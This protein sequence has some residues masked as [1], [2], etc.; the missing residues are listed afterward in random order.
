MATS[1]RVFNNDDW[2]QIISNINSLVAQCPDIEPLEPVDECHK[3]SKEDIMGAQGKLLEGCPSNSFSPIPDLWKVA[4]IQELEDAIEAGP[5]CAEDCPLCDFELD[6]S[7]D[8]PQGTG[9]F[10]DGWADIFDHQV[11][12]N[13]LVGEFDDL[14]LEANDIVQEINDLKE[15]LATAAT[16]EAAAAIQDMID[17]KKEELDDKIDEAETK[18]DEIDTLVDQGWDTIYTL[19]GETGDQYDIS[20]IVNDNLINVSEPYFEN[21]ANRLRSCTPVNPA[22]CRVFLLFSSGFGG[23]NNVLLQLVP[24]GRFTALGG[25]SVPLENTPNLK[26][27]LKVIGSVAACTPEM[28]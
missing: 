12:V 15:M 24:G 18:S 23:E 13:D 7:E 10:S 6:I 2:N 20:G 28:P 19:G 8:I 17:D 21:Y 9:T 14:I 1:D 16:P 11:A 26:V 27:E 22:I 3:L 4:P 25:D 5:C